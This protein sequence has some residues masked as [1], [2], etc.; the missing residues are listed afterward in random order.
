MDVF[1]C[2]FSAAFS[3]RLFV[4]VVVVVVLVVVVVVVVVIFGF[5]HPNNKSELVTSQQVLLLD[6]LCSMGQ[7]GSYR[8]VSFDRFWIDIYNI[9]HK[10]ET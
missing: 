4:V 10:K 5:N 6:H 3:I 9:F 1:L 8:S 7:T 2:C